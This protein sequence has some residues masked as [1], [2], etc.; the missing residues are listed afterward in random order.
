MCSDAADGIILQCG[1]E[2]GFAEEA[3][4]TATDISSLTGEQLCGLPTGNLKC[5][6]HLSVFDNRAGKVAKC[7]NHK[8][9]HW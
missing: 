4:T 7:R 9:T 2:Y 3:S 1:K 8:F 6:R 5:E